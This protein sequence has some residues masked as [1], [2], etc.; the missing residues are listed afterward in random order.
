MVKLPCP[1]TIQDGA[2]FCLKYVINDL[3]GIVASRHLHIAD[4]AP[5]GSESQHCLKLAE[6]HSDAVDFTKTGHAVQIQAMPKALLRKPDFLCPEWRINKPSEQSYES[7]KILGRL[8]RDV[9]LYDLA[10]PR[11]SARGSPSRV[12]ELGGITPAVSGIRVDGVP[13]GALGLPH[14]KV[15]EELSYS[16]EPFATPS[17]TSLGSTPSPVAATDISPRS[18]SSPV[19]SRP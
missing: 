12:D 3:M 13:G 11:R 1:C 2:E 7:S 10:T 6:L 14:R 8:F 16:I 15:V 18:R 4:T 19:Q 5:E 9:P 17:S